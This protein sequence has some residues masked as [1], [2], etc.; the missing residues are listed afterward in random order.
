[1]QLLGESQGIIVTSSLSRC[2]S[3]QELAGEQTGTHCPLAAKCHT[4]PSTPDAAQVSLLIAACPAIC[5]FQSAL[6]RSSAR[7][8]CLMC[9]ADSRVFRT[10][11]GLR[12]PSEAERLGEVP[13]SLCQSPPLGYRPART[14]ISQKR[15]LRKRWETEESYKCIAPA[16]RL[17]NW[18]GLQFCS[19]YQVC[20][21]E[22]Q[23]AQWLLGNGSW[24]LSVHSGC[25]R[26]QR[27]AV[28]MLTSQWVR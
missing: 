25:S 22:V 16:S 21:S 13:A 7:S 12:S 5:H 20:L 1:M 28:L 3:C 19:D 11:L 27:K 18:L 2:C 14:L 9:R 23:A 4:S 24:V 26:C 15:R 8:W 6:N 17:P 10:H